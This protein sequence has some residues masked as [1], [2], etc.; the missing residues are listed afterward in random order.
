VQQEGTSCVPGSAWIGM[1]Q[2][3]DAHGPRA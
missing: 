1:S 2:E 3:E